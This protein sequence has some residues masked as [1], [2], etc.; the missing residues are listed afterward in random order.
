MAQRS[1]LMADD[2][3]GVLS[4]LGPAAIAGR[5]G[6]VLEFMRLL[7]A[8]DHALHSTSK[9]MEARLG[10]TG[11][12][13]L[14]IRMIGRFPGVSAGA[15]ADLLHVH[16]STLTGVLRRLTG[17]GAIRRTADPRDSRRALFWLT[18]RGQ[19]I[20]RLRSGT[21]EAAVTR[22]LARAPARN[23]AAAR[24]MLARVTLE[25]DREVSGTNGSRRVSAAGR[26]GR[27]TALPAR[28][29]GRVG[30]GPAS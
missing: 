15:L 23:L 7:W 29:S 2:D 6:R 24:T 21:V 17:R 28:P 5:L 20:D 12:Q 30:A 1:S 16:P 27:G 26:R 14:V 25:L 13:R 18:A 4:R 10:I 11:P 9:W 19:G 3:F 22:A 8:L